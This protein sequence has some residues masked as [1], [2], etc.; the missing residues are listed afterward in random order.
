[1]KRAPGHH[2]GYTFLGPGLGEQ[3]E[4][5]LNNLGT[6]FKYLGIAWR[7]RD[8]GLLVD[9][10]GTLGHKLGTTKGLIG[11]NLGTI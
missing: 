7:L 4:T 2:K 10:L 6:T 1:M 5:T 3:F 9:H 8:N 11:N